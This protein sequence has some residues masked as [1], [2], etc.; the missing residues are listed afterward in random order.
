MMMCVPGALP[1]FDGNRKKTL[2]ICHGL[3]GSHYYSHLNPDIVLPF[4]LPLSDL[5][6]LKAG[7]TDETRTCS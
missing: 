6:G 2:K 1:S 7:S 3:R 4:R 5:F